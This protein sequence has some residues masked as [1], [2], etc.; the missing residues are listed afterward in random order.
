LH[1]VGGIRPRPAIGRYKNEVIP[2]GSYDLVGGC[3]AYEFHLRSF[4]LRV[5]LQRGSVGWPS[6]VLIGMLAVIV[7]TSERDRIVNGTSSASLALDLRP[8]RPRRAGARDGIDE[9]REA[10]VHRAV[11]GFHVD[12]VSRPPTATMSPLACLARTSLMRPKLTSE[13]HS[14]CS[15]PRPRSTTIAL[16]TMVLP[17]VVVRCSG[18]R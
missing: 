8:S 2:I 7:F 9:H 18:A 13:N 17:A 14:G 12:F 11:L 1:P 10:H 15:S 3:P 4:R 16:V 6:M 5:G